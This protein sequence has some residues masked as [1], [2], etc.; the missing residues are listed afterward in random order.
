M[1]T[2]GPIAAHVETVG[3]LAHDGKS[4][5]FYYQERSFWPLLSEQQ[6]VALEDIM[7]KRLIL[8]ASIATAFAPAAA[9]AGPVEDCLLSA[10]CIFDW[11]TMEWYCPDPKY[12]MLCTE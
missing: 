12:Y 6:W 8:I 10:N 9:T 1:S 7:L 4:R 3:E 11:G 2:G 5:Y